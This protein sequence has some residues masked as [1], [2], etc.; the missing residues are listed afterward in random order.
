MGRGW[1]EDRPQTQEATDV[2]EVLKSLISSF[3]FSDN[4]FLNIIL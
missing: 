2:Q 1:A 3:Y 4:P